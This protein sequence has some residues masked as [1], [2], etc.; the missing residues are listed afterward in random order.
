MARC[1]FPA[2]CEAWPWETTS[3]SPWRERACRAAWTASRALLSWRAELSSRFYH[4][5]PS[6]FPYQWKPQY[7]FHPSIS[8]I[9]ISI[10]H[11]ICPV[12]ITIS[13]T[14]VSPI[15]GYVPIWPDLWIWIPNGRNRVWTW[16]QQYAPAIFWDGDPQ[17]WQAH[18]P[19]KKTKNSW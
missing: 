16:T 17:S 15:F 9:S 11:I 3:N 10:F 12:D 6:F 8:T 2:A 1:R 5:F 14:G 18:I 7:H 19:N 4:P 13:T